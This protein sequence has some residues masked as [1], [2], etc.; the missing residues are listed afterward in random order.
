MSHVRAALVASTV[1][2]GA[3]LAGCS[4][5]PGTAAVVDG[6][7][8]SQD[9]LDRTVAELTP[10]LG[11][12]VPRDVLVSLIA[13]PLYI[14]AAEESGVGVSTVE[15]RDQLDQVAEQVGAETADWSESTIEL[16]RSS[17][18]AQNLQG[19]DPEAFAAVTEELLAA[20]ITVNPRYGR[21]DHEAREI[22]PIT[23]PWIV[24]GPAAEDAEGTGPVQD[25]PT[26]E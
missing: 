6:R 4:A 26:T 18:A 1:V 19:E 10:L 20:D 24:A 9:S 14:E 7:T 5:Q 15:I 25:S 2:V 3:L 8:V 13:A 11:E 16:V 21:F 23:W 17:F 22:V 12:A